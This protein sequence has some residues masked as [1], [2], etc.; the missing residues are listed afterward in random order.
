MGAAEGQKEGSRLHIF[1]DL[2]FAYQI[3]F[4]LGWIL[5]TQITWDIMRFGG[6]GMGIG[7]K[8]AQILICCYDLSSKE[9][10]GRPAKEKT[11]SS[12]S[13]PAPPGAES[14]CPRNLGGRRC[15]RLF[16][17]LCWRLQ[18]P[19]GG[20]PLPRSPA[21][22]PRTMR[23]LQLLPQ[24]SRGHPWWGGGGPSRERGRRPRLKSEYFW[25]LVKIQGLPLIC[26]TAICATSPGRTSVF[27]SIKW[28]WWSLSY[29]IAESIK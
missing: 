12:S 22:H 8:Y 24:L 26:V 25:T 9:S 19:P 11:G 14:F 2:F 21:L 17:R 4:S 7:G 5:T 13:V 28:W 1:L 23:T 27:L 16:A 18:T 20:G 6:G 29:R 15:Q 3:Y 10:G